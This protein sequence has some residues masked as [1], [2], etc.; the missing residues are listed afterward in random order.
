L[1]LLLFPVCVNGVALSPSV[2]IC[3]VVSLAYRMW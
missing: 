2:I 3:V 1:I